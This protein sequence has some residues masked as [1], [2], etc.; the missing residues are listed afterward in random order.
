MRNHS[1][2]NIDSLRWWCAYTCNHATRA[3]KNL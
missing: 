1:S 2:N 3:G